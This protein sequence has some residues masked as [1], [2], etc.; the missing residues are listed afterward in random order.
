ML[1]P[2]CNDGGKQMQFIQ[3]YAVLIGL[4]F[5]VLMYVGISFEHMH[6]I[7][8][9]PISLIGGIFLW[10]IAILAKRPDVEH[11][12]NEAGSEIVEIILFLMAA[13]TLVEFLDQKGFFELI[14]VQLYRR[15]L[16]DLLHNVLPEC[17]LG[18]PN[19]N[20]R[21]VDDC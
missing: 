17:C 7:Q 9:E 3:D 10:V 18:Q 14:R 21:H 5:F 2:C 1:D 8:K 13:M 16:R 15:N 11:H 4:G 12:L 6:G 19:D 20:A